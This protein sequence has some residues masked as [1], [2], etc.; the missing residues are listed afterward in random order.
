MSPSSSACTRAARVRFHGLAGLRLDLG[1]HLRLGLR[2]ALRLDGL[3][4]LALAPVRLLGLDLRARFRLDLRAPLGF[5]ALGDL[6][7]L[8]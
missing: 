8:A 2:A 6:L 1:A 7:L 3:L 4:Q 5:Q